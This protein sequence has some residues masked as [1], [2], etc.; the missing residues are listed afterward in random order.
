MLAGIAAARAFN[1]VGVRG[2]AP[3]A[4]IAGSNWLAVQSLDALEAA[5]LS[6]PGANEIAVSNNSWGKYFSDET[7]YE[8]ILAE[9]ATKLRD[10]KGRIYIFASGNAREDNADAN[11]QFIINNRYA[12]VV[13]ALNYDNKIAS[14]STPGANIWTVAYGGNDDFEKGPTI[15]TTYLS[16]QSLYTWNEDEKK[17]YTYAMAGSSAAAPMVTGAVALI[18]EACPNLT[19]RD[20][21]YIIAKSAS[22]VDA[23]NSSWITNSAGVHFSRD[24]GFGLINTQA[25]IDMCS[26]NYTLLSK[27]Q[28]L[29]NSL[30]EINENIASSKTATIT[31][32]KNIKIEWVEAIIDLEASNASQI[33]IYL[34]SPSG[35]RVQL[36]QS[37]T[38]IGEYYIPD[39]NWMSGGFRFSTGALL[40]ENS[41]GDWSIEIINKE[42]NNSV[43]LYNIEL[44]IYGH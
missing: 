28:T 19:Y 42:S 8:D 27:E 9:G 23:Q 26:N 41:L 10:G 32:D 25:A 38:K 31:I 3:Y 20:V 5:W 36:L 18:L 40:D 21:K 13:G 7:L 43:T 37:G 33:D 1:N 11:I 2:V 29:F 15:A 4:K 6:G 44:Q 35:T 22:K 39:S 24:Y 30:D 16:N 34:I 17:N 12:L 14:Y